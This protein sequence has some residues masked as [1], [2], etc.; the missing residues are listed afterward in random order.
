MGS[1][2]TKILVAVAAASL[3]KIVSCTP[4]SCLEE[5]DTYLI[6]PL[7]KSSQEKNVAPD[8]LTLYGLNMEDDKIYDKTK[9]I[10]SALIPLNPSAESCVFVIGINSATDTLIFWYTTFPHLISKECGYTYFHA[11]DSLTNTGNAI[12]TVIIRNRYITTSDE[13]NIRIYY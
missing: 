13:E 2:K 5:T 9:S 8:S 6:A 12:D 7:Y 11:L 10:K 3:L 4:E 1:F